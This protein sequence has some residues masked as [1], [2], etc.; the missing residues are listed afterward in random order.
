[1]SSELPEAILFDLDD[2]IL[3]YESVGEK[4]WRQACRVFAPQVPGL[5]ADRL[6]TAIKLTLAWYW[7]D[8]ERNRL[9]RLDLLAA[10]REIVSAAFNSIDVPSPVVS[11]KIADYFTENR[12]TAVEAL[13]GAIDTL[14]RLRDDGVKL[15]L[16]TNGASLPQRA[17]IDRF[18]LEP[19]FESILVEGEFG[20]GK[21]D[22]RVYLH[23]LEQLGAQPH[24]AWM[25]GD[26]LEFDVAGP[27]RLGISGVWVDWRCSGLPERS[28]VQPDRI[29][30]RISELVEPG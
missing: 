12:E 5:E 28:P 26:H 16:I 25:V 2:T 11:D 22:E 30:T 24:E 14:H 29:I 6:L 19:L 15:A 4:C 8:P 18:G 10:R 9:G 3:A 13:P 20:A 1:M 27:K 21:P 17:K 7:G 23:S